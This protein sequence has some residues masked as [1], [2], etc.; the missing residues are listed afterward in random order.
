ME[1]LI[2]VRHGQ[3]DHNVQRRLQGQIDIPMNATGA[4]Q[5][6]A[7]GE[8]LSTLSDVAAVYT[9]PLSRARATA[10]AIAVRHG[11]GVH[12]DPRLLERSFGEWEGLTRDEVEAGWPEDFA[13]W[14]GGHPIAGAGVEDR[15]AVADRF[16]A[17]CRSYADAHPGPS[18]VIVVSHGA[19]ISL[20]I[21]A[22]LGLDTAHFRGF[23]G[24]DN[25]ARAILFPQDNGT[26]TGWVRL[27]SLNLPADFPA[28][29]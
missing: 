3:T 2:L 25:C 14:V 5:A 15:E 8:S 4:A 11:L 27:A 26:A 21:A 24:L 10:E 17:A 22:M 12:G 16:N 29:A 19:A 7:V 20:G 6:E 28:P 23:Q 9:S 1:R 18:T 13:N